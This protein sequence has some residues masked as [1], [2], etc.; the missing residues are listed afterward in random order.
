LQGANNI[1]SIKS[2]KLNGEVILKGCTENEGRH[3]VTAAMEGKSIP[4][5]AWTDPEVSRRVRGPDFNKIS[6]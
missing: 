2:L 4:L 1:E 3:I 5:Q 6:T